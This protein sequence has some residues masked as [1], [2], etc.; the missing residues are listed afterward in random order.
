MIRAAAWLCTQHHGVFAPGG[1]SWQRPTPS[2]LS[3][4]VGRPIKYAQ[5]LTDEAWNCL[6]AASLAHKASKFETSE[7]GLLTA[8][9]EGCRDAQENYFRDYVA[10]GRA[11]GRGNLFIYTL[12]TSV[13]GEVGIV[14]SL[15]GP[16]MFI[17]D[18]VRPLPALLEHAGQMLSDGEAGAMLLLWCDSSA[19]VCLAIDGNAESQAFPLGLE[20]N[21]SE[22]C[23]QLQQLVLAL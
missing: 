10:N 14:L 20:S 21:P 19:A 23:R 22:L 2:D 4:L 12:P 11:L 5:R 13:A 9:T 15:R 17:R 16:C 1:E 8:G 6:C 7:I 3:S 18:D